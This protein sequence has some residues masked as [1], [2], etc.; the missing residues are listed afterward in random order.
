MAHRAEG[1]GTSAQKV[2]GESPLEKRVPVG[3]E[4]DTVAD[5]FSAFDRRHIES[6]KLAQVR[7]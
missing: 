1:H 5:I 3:D 6:A 7:H 4:V 2:G